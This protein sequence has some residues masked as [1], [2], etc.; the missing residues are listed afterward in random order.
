MCS[1]NRTV[2]VAKNKAAHTSLSYQH[3]EENV[4]RF[5]MEREDLRGQL[6]GV[7][8]GGEAEGGVQEEDGRSQRPSVTK[9][10]FSIITF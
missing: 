4:T 7:S 2:M 10:Y 6:E 8:Q 1:A 5:V 3:L 9:R